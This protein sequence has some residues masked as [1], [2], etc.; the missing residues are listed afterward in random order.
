MMADKRYESDDPAQSGIEGK[1][2]NYFQ[3]GHN[4]CEFLLDFGQVYSDGTPEHF[5]PRIVTSPLY[6]KEL[7]KVLSESIEQYEETFGHRLH[8]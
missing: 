7:L 2:A 5:H 4:A 6:A 8:K 3:V 1:Y